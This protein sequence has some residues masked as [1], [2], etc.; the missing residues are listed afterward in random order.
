V[1]GDPVGCARRERVF[2]RLIGDL[3]ARDR[4]RNGLTVLLHGV[5]GTTNLDLP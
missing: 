2:P 5:A 4:F 3:S 1:V